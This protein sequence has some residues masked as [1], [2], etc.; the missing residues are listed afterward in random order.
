MSI[1]GAR[2]VEVVSDRDVYGLRM[3]T[4]ISIG[5]GVA[6][7]RMWLVG[8]SI[9][10]L[11]SI[12]FQVLDRGKTTLVL[13]STD[14]VAAQLGGRIKFIWF[15]RV[16][17]Q[18]PFLDVTEVG[19]SGCVFEV[20]RNLSYELVT[21]RCPRVAEVRSRVEC[22]QGRYQSAWHRRCRIPTGN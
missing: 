1:T 18:E 4:D 22:T 16:V 12:L 8:S 6:S 11:Y 10:R 2:L 5:Y 17:G 13:G 7:R 19:C 21:P 14:V 20:F 15:V 9:V 3:H